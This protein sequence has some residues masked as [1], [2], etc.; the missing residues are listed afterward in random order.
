MPKQ[1][2]QRKPMVTGIAGGSGSGKSTVAAF[3]RQ[4]GM[5][6]ID[7]DELARSL[8]RKEQPL[9]KAIVTV[10]GPFFLD[11]RGNILRAKLGRVVFQ[12]WTWL[13]R[14]N[15]ATHPLLKRDLQQSLAHSTP[16]SGI[17]IEGAVLYEAG[18]LPFLD[19]L[20]FVDCQ[21]E[22]RIERM[23]RK[24]LSRAQA[25]ARLYSQRF[26]P[27]LRRRATIVIP[28]NGTREELKKRVQDIC[29]EK[30]PHLCSLI[31]YS[32]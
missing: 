32:R 27:C 13:F 30:N 31:P 3:F 20:I 26:L 10:W 12:S 25:I 23:I 8:T 15:Q 22:I 6:V 14:L 11:P 18:L 1:T 19:H 5:T 21:D 4:Q 28:N 9:W 17:V 7:L 2:G 24:G 29:H 16:D